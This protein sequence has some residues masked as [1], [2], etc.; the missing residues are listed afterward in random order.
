MHRRF[1]SVVAL[2]A[3]YALVFAALMGALGSARAA[4]P[5]GLQ[6]CIAGDASGG[7]PPAKAEHKLCCSLACAGGQPA[8][9]G[10]SVAPL[11]HALGCDMSVSALAAVPGQFER[12][13]SAAPRGPPFLA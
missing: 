3:A 9:A 4:I 1:R 7:T 2:C 8:L 13:S 12:L 10:G 5:D 6:L 11:T